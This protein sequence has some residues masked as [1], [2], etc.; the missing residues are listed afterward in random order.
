MVMIKEIVRK[1]NKY[2][3]ALFFNKDIAREMPIYL[4]EIYIPRS[5]D[6]EI[7][8]RIKYE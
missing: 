1:D 3:I 6:L 5:S 7:I 8:E 2:Y 4:I